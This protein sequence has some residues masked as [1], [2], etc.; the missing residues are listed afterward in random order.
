MVGHVWN[1]DKEQ[2]L[3]FDLKRDYIR[4]MSQAVC[5][6]M[7]DRYFYAEALHDSTHNDTVKTHLNELATERGIDINNNIHE[8][9]NMCRK[10]KV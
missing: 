10:I 7:Q 4:E 5:I 3:K 6:Q 2:Y 8:T 1:Q 9:F